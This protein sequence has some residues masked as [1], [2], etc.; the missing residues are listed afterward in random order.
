VNHGTTTAYKHGCRCDECAVEHYRY[1]KA[2][3][4]RARERKIAGRAVITAPQT[5]PAADVIRHLWALVDSGWTMTQ[6]AAELGMGRNH[7]WN[8]RAGKFA[9]LRPAT[10]A[11]VLSLAPLEP[12]DLDP[13]VVDRLIAGA[14]WRALGATRAERVAAAERAWSMYGPQRRAAKEQGTSD[15][16]LPGES[17]TSLEDRLGL[18]A[19]RDFSRA[20]A[21]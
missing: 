10:A 3:A 17:L 2:Y 14:D 21:S 16:A 15:Q 13:V 8:I 6:I 5:V 12:V 18:R 11:R 9:R 7:L 20:V 1:R 4:L 19:G